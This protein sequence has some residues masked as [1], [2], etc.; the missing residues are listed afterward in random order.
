MTCAAPKPDVL[1]IFM[2]SFIINFII[3]GPH[4]DH[5]HTTHTNRST[6]LTYSYTVVIAFELTDKE[7]L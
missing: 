3:C 4:S 6:A 5:S 7:L 1:S 2:I